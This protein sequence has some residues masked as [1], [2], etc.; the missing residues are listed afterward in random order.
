MSSLALRLEDVGKVFDGSTEQVHAVREASLAV[1]TGEVVL[2]MGPSG[3][4]KTTLL[5]MCGA[6]LRPSAGR[7]WLGD[8]EITDVPE[9]Q[10]PATRLRE[11]GFV[12]QA[13][14]LLGNLTAIENVRIVLE[15]AGVRPRQSE[16]RARTLLSDLGLARRADETPERL[17]GGERQRVAI[18]R[19]LA[20]DPPL[21]LAD[22][23]TANL[24]ARTGYQ[25]MHTLEALAKER[26]KT[27]VAVTH[28]HRIVDVADRVLWLEDG[29]LSDQPP[30]AEPGHGGWRR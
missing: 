28:D 15:Q 16:A 29:V 3:S 13:F 27:V 1:E 14:S 19:A 30:A 26:G 9:R 7:I 8:V 20:N 10:L 17:S 21:L 5:S 6:L 23:P 12:F 24:D 4:G 18:A 22:E 2:V 11:V 25:V